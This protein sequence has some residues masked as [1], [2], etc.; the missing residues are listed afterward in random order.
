MVREEGGVSGK[1]TSSPSSKAQSL[2]TEKN[3][4]HRVPSIVAWNQILQFTLANKIEDTRYIFHVIPLLI[5]ER[6][7]LNKNNLSL[8]EVIDRS[9][10]KTYMSVLMVDSYALALIAF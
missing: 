8:A 9:I 5:K 6:P 10:A 1:V 3:I 4:P 7:F 2:P